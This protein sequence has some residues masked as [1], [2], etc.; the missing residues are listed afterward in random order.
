MDEPRYFTVF[1][2]FVGVEACEVRADSPAD[3]IEKSLLESA[4]WENTF[5]RDST[6]D[7]DDV[8]DENGNSVMP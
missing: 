5:D 6:D 8:H 7:P 2:T 3:A 4:V 1:R